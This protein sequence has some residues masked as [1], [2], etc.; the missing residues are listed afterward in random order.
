[1]PLLIRQRE[2]QETTGELPPNIKCHSG[3]KKATIALKIKGDEE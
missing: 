1:M 3:R 2:V